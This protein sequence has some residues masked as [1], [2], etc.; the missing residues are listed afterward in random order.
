MEQIG[1]FDPKTTEKAT[2]VV[3]ILLPEE[4]WPAH[5]KYLAVDIPLDRPVEGLPDMV[6]PPRNHEV[7]KDV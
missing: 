1:L 3:A 2:L 4:L 5:G 6:P 7:I